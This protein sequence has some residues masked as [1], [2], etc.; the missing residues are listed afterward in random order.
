ML[1]C[2][3]SRLINLDNQNDRKKR[4]YLDDYN[5]FGFVLLQKSDTEVP[6]C[7]ICLET[8]TND[9]MRLSGLKLHLTTVHA[10]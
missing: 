9:A 3:R 6:Q 10:A 4:K 8:L 5:H 2:L 1:Q 7:V